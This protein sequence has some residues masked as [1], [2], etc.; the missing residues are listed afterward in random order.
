[1]DSIQDHYTD[2]QPGIQRKVFKVKE[3]V[4]WGDDDA[5]HSTVCPASSLHSL[6]AF[7]GPCFVVLL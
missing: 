5:Q 7:Q 1:L 4:R 6:A 2:A 3:L